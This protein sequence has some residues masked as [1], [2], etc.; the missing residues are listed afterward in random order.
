MEPYDD[1]SWHLSLN[2]LVKRLKEFDKRSLSCEHDMLVY[3]VPG[4]L[5]LASQ[6]AL[7]ARAAHLCICMTSYYYH[8]YN[9]QAGSKTMS[10]E[11]GIMSLGLRS[12]LT[13][14]GP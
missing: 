7:V 11:H 13:A 10:N 6:P 5:Q 8:Y 3:T 12:A 1:A 2:V 9:C 14:R 4:L